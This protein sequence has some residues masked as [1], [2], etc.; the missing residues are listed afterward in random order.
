MLRRGVLA[1]RRICRGPLL[2][3]RPR[4]ITPR[5]VSRLVVLGLPTIRRAF[6]GITRWASRTPRANKQS[7]E[8]LDDYPA[9]Y[10]NCSVT[11]EPAREGTTYTAMAG[12]I[13]LR[14]TYLEDGSDLPDC[15]ATILY[16]AELEIV[17][18][19]VTDGNGQT[20]IDHIGPLPETIGYWHCE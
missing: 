5:I 9:R 18:L 7:R 19:L 3:V 8:V 2:G 17:D 16:E 14:L 6:G 11:G 4:R 20:E 12:F 15:P 13:Q 1:R 10:E